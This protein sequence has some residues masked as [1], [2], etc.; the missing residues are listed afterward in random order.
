MRL[1]SELHPVVIVNFHP[2]KPRLN[3]V[4]PVSIHA[5]F[6]TPFDSQVS[7]SNLMLNCADESHLIVSCWC[8]RAVRPS[9]CINACRPRQQERRCLL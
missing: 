3:G 8:A 7:L 5:P 6:K 2:R 4:S 1:S 9:C